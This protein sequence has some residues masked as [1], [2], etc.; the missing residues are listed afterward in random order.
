MNIKTKIVSLF[1]IIL[2]LGFSLSVRAAEKN[3]IPIDEETIFICSNLDMYADFA[4][5]GRDSAMPRDAAFKIVSDSMKRNLKTSTDTLSAYVAVVG[6]LYD[7]IYADPAIKRTGAQ[8]AIVEACSQYK[9]RKADKRAINDYLDQHPLSAW[10]PLERVPLCEKIAQSA[11]NLAAARDKGISKESADAMARGGLQND[12]LTLR[13]VPQLLTEVYENPDVGTFYIY[14]Y[15]V[16]RCRAKEKN[17]KY[18]ELREMNSR[19][20]N[21]QKLEK[22]DDELQCVRTMFDL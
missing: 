16:A 9:G 15:N 6:K 11:S 7:L 5:N 21:C 18:L 14:G 8:A 4:L 13:S 17:E 12:Q 20:R 3:Q 19:I 10:D 2:S 1:F 22:K